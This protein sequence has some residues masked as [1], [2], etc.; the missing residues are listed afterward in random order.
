MQYILE[1]FTSVYDENYSQIQILMKV[2]RTIN[3]C[4]IKTIFKINTHTLSSFLEPFARFQRA[5]FSNL[6]SNAHDSAR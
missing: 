3:T 5:Q 1:K 2:K 4:I 6:T